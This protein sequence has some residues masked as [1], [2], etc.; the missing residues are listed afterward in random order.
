MRYEEVAN[1]RYGKNTARAVLCGT[2]QSTQTVSADLRNLRQW[3]KVYEQCHS[4]VSLGAI[5]DGFYP[6]SLSAARIGVR[7]TL[8]MAAR[9]TRSPVI[10]TAAKI[11]ASGAHA[12]RQ[13]E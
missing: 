8:R 13:R 12:R 6:S 7:T 4:Q 2:F 11:A 10:S 9:L 1:Y 5:I 3:G